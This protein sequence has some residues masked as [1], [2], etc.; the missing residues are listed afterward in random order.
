VAQDV[1]PEFKPQYCQKKKKVSAARLWFPVI[2]ATWEAEI[3]K[4][5]VR[6]HL[7]QIV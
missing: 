3:K 4:I 1:G 5:A 2:L 7:G 6:D